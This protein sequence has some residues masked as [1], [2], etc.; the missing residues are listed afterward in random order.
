MSNVISDKAAPER[1]VPGEPATDRESVR[2]PLSQ[3]PTR[4][5]PQEPTP[6]RPSGLPRSGGGGIP[7][8]PSGRHAPSARQ[9][10]ATPNSAAAGNPR[11][12]YVTRRAAG[13]LP[14]VTKPPPATRR[15]RHGRARCCVA[16][17]TTP[18]T[19]AYRSG[20]DGPPGATQAAPAR[21]RRTGDWTYTNQ[22]I[23]ES[24]DQ[25]GRP[26]CQSDWAHARGCTRATPA[27]A[28]RGGEGGRRQQAGPS[29]MRRQR[30]DRAHARSRRPRDYVPRVTRRVGG[31]RKAARW[32]QR[33]AR[34][35]GRRAP[36]A[37]LPPARTHARREGAPQTAR[38]A[39]RPTP[40]T[41]R[42]N[43]CVQPPPARLRPLTRRGGGGG[44]VAPQAARRA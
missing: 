12:G 33:D 39:K 13:A 9:G 22:S 32:A 18:A 28:S 43:P 34:H 26:G 20:G 30:G 5:V 23:S 41:R 7:R 19:P 29:G 27:P 36:R 35:R 25:D 44:G 14:L 17:G 31:R 15:D 16:N 38:R 21:Q 8:L 40:P 3:K 6:L 11:R 24:A 4:Q 1:N 10:K 2:V 42:P 37:R